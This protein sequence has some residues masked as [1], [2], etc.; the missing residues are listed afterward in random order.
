MELKQKRKI[1]SEAEAIIVDTQSGSE[2]KQSEDEAKWKNVDRAV[3]WTKEKGRM[4]QERRSRYEN[5]KVE[6][7]NR[8]D[9]LREAEGSDEEMK[10]QTD[11]EDK[12]TEE[13]NKET[14]RKCAE[15]GENEKTTERTNGG[16][17]ESVKSKDDN[18][19]QKETES[20]NNTEGK[21]RMGNME[22]RSK[23]VRFEGGVAMSNTEK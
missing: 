8:F 11:G 14:K 12:E 18:K 21:N 9:A 15:K 5:P 1:P 10:G 4:K 17:E 6:I 13:G 2:T 22:N 20:R 16:K 23:G 7:A 19:D 3:S